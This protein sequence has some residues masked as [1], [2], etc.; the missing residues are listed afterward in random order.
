MKSRAMPSPACRGAESANLRGKVVTVKE[1]GAFVEFLPART[2]RAHQRTGELPRQAN[3]DIVK[4]AMTSRSNAWVDEKGRV[5]LSR[6]AAMAERDQ[7]W[8]KRK[9]SR[10]HGNHNCKFNQP[11]RTGNRSRFL[12]A[13]VLRLAL[14]PL[15][16]HC[17]QTKH[18]GLP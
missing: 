1:F 14:A 8:R 3:R 9:N 4:V 12:F 10:N 17:A 11:A 2:S 18:S 6:K 13:F 15:G 7:K 16:A 5:R